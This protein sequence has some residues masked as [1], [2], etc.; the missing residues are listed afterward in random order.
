MTPLP[1]RVLRAA[2]VALAV[3]AVGWFAIAAADATGYVLQPRND[4]TATTMFL[5]GTVAF[6]L[7]ALI[8]AGALLAVGG[9][10]G[11]PRT[12]LILAVAAVTLAALVYRYTGVA[13][14]HDPV[15]RGYSQHHVAWI[16][17]GWIT[18][19]ATMCSAGFGRGS[20]QRGLDR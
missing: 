20:A 1:R 11:W 10:V 5:V 14:E 2:A 4:A 13:Q 9:E 16:A 17:F 8:A 18:V 19:A 12:A 7:P 3:G 15:Y 6:G